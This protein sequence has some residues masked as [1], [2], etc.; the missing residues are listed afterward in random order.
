LGRR[1]VLVNVFFAAHLVP[2]QMA[3]SAPELV[4]FRVPSFHQQHNIDQG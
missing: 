3:I 1:R 2:L 4:C